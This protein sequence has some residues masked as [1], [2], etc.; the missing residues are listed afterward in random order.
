MKA[1]FT[2]EFA[3]K[4]GLIVNPW[5]CLYS[6]IEMKSHKIVITYHYYSAVC[7]FSFQHCVCMCVCVYT[8]VVME[9]HSENGKLDKVYEM[10]HIRNGVYESKA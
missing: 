8:V 9:Q 3:R 7:R 6:D 4:I 2:H 10:A 5:L 1:L